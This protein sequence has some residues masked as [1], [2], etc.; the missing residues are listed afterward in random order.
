MNLLAY[1][2]RNLT[3]ARYFAA[4]GAGYIT[5]NAKGQTSELSVHA[6]TAMAEWIAGPGLL[7]VAPNAEKATELLGQVPF[8]GLILPSE[9]LSLVNPFLHMECFA[10]INCKDESHLEGLLEEAAEMDSFELDGILLN[11]QKIGTIT[12]NIGMLING[13]ASKI[14]VFADISGDFHQIGA[15]LHKCPQLGLVLHG[16]EEEKVGLKSFDEMDD[17]LENWMGEMS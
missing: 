3:D 12:D 1:D 9:N 4:R 13:L 5:F 7:L 2:I 16:A 15:V 8:T 11:L 6:M 17:F 10:E 14:P